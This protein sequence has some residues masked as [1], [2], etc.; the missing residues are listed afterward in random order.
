MVHVTL[1]NVGRDELGGA[2]RLRLA[3]QLRR[4][5][6]E[7]AALHRHELL[8]EALTGFTELHDRLRHARRRDAQ[9]RGRAREPLADLAHLAERAEPGDRLDA[10][11][12]GPDALFFGDEE[13]S[14]VAGAM[15]VRAA[16]QL[17][18]GTGLDHA[19]LVVVLL[20][21]QRHS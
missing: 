17:A 5:S 2:Y 15:A 13:R 11:D 1:A 3:Q 18:T 16:A 19:D 12:A 8:L 7:A 21:E 6:V 10:P 20:A 14:D 9:R 4:D